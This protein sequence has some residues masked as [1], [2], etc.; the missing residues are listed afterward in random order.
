MRKPKMK[1]TCID[2]HSEELAGRGAF[3]AES[4]FYK[5]LLV[6]ILCVFGMNFHL[7]N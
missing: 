4:I 2:E 5:Y 7:Q 6:K 1:H 3:L